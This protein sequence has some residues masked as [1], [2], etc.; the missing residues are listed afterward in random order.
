MAIASG[1]SFSW[2]GF[3]GL[4]GFMQGEM[5]RI[6]LI[7]L[8]LVGCVQVNVPM[9]QTADEPT[10]KVEVK[11]S[12]PTLV[13]ETKTTTVA[14]PKA[15]VPQSIS[16]GRPPIAPIDHSSAQP[17]PVTLVTPVAQ[18]TEAEQILAIQI[19]K[20]KRNQ[21]DFDA[22]DKLNLLELKAAQTLLRVQAVTGKSSVSSFVNVNLDAVRGLHVTD[23]LP[24]TVNLNR[25]FTQRGDASNSALAPADPI[26][27]PLP[28]LTPTVAPTVVP[29]V[30]PPPPNPPIPTVVTV[31]K[32]TLPITVT[33]DVGDDIIIEAT[34][35]GQTLAWWIDPK[36]NLKDSVLN[37]LLDPKLN[38][39]VVKSKIAGVYSVMAL[40]AIDGVMSAPSV[41]TVTVTGPIAPVIVTPVVVTPVV[42]PTVTPVTP[43][44][45][46][47]VT[48][49]R[50][51]IIDETSAK[52]T[53]SQ[54]AII[55]STAIRAYL[56][57]HCIKS[58]DGIPEWR[59][60]D[61]DI[62]LGSSVSPTMKKMFMDLKADISNP[63]DKS[64]LPVIVVSSG[65]KGQFFQITP[66][67]TEAAVLAML[68]TYGGN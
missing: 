26:A 23:T 47:T 55:N 30:D 44:P 25:P 28:V 61:P 20:A 36:S 60:W 40:T 63:L 27:P 21:A 3:T 39:R 62:T 58:P 2:R 19:D 66:T 54:R 53:A 67:T 4:V 35:N 14:Q 32:V 24:K 9:A 45:D 15:Y 46:A 41:C 43:T 56:S 64:K 10:I 50:A 51:L 7:V 6:W 8:I 65:T 11:P 29:A 37:K 49:F 48:G 33:G 38:A 57:S 68:R 1:L 12:K 31:P 5:M 59:E 16:I 42:T 22:S 13:D 34:T 18:L 52:V 17:Q